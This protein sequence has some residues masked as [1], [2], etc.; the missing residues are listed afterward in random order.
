[1][2]TQNC[3]ESVL[4]TNDHLTKDTPQ[5]TLLQPDDTW[6]ITESVLHNIFLNSQTI[7]NYPDHSILP[8]Q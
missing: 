1:M 6:L 3:D 4:E 2:F 7:S 8:H 5:A